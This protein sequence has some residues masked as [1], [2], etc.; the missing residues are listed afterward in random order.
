MTKRTLRRD[1]KRG[2]EKKKNKREGKNER[3]EKRVLELHQQKP[4]P[5]SKATVSHVLKLHRCR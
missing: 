2:E 3:A 1:E 4:H 5:T